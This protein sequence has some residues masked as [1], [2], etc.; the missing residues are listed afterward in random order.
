MP[1]RD[2]DERGEG[3]HDQ[4]AA[5]EGIEDTAAGFT[6]GLGDVDQEMPVDLGDACFEDI[7]K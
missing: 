6:D 7:E 1:M 4:D 2:S 3:K 5:D